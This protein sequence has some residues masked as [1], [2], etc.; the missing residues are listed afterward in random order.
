MKATTSEQLYT[1]GTCGGLPEILP[2]APTLD[3]PALKA[4]FRERSQARTGPD[5]S[6]VW[7]YREL[8]APGFPEDKIVTRGEGNTGFYRHPKLMSWVGLAGGD[9][10]LKH[11]GE[12]PTGS[13]KDRGMCV[14]VSQAL[15]E[16]AKIM[17]CASTGNTSA[18]LSSYAALAG[19]AAVVFVPAG[20]V[21]TGK[22][23]QTIAYGARVLKVRGNFDQALQ[24]VEE[25][26]DRFGMALLNS[27][28]PWRIEGQK[29]IGL[30][31]LDDL[32][33]DAP[34][35]I[36]L[37]SGNLG[38]ISALGKA[39]REA[40]RAGLIDKLPRVACVQAAGSAPFARLFDARKTDP[41]AAYVAED[42]PETLATAIRIGDPRSW[43]KALREVGELGGTVI[44]VPDEEILEAKAHVDAAGIGCE[45]ASAASVAGLKRLVADGTIAKDARVVSILTGHLLKDPET[46]AKYHQSQLS[47]IS[48][49]SANPFH[50]VDA[51][52]GAIE[53]ALSDLL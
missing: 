27:V 5:R 15:R 22:M 2:N 4:L 6:G 32:G 47:G 14:G 41:E 9:Y 38:N 50:E 49:A 21:S 39:L 46:T 1:Q 7:R 16:G 29:G 36:V 53:K 26:C 3:G 42:T 48:S 8:V 33:W 28:N 13:F 43:G 19:V 34:D 37:P 24:L 12:N 10:A 20:K 45:P 51:E 31:I 18:S 11:E 23:A 52:L 25:A 35:W 30:E 44:S 40:K 17:A